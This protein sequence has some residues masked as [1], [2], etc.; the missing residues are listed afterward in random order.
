MK[1]SEQ[2][3]ILESWLKQ[4]QTLLFKVVRAYAFSASDQ[5]DLFQEIMIQVWHSI[6]SFKHQSKPTTWLYRVSLNT[7]LTW[8]RKE[9]KHQEG[10]QPIENEDF[11]L[12][13]RSNTVDGRLIWLYE[14]ITRLNEIDRSLMLLLLDG[15]SYKE[16]SDILGISESNVG[17]KISRIKKHLILQSKLYEHHGI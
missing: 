11:I 3:Q 1:E 16:M 14:E 6:P 4:Y 17:V 9:R 13:E 5:E 10:R 15:F 7:A 12:K 8:I 2:Q